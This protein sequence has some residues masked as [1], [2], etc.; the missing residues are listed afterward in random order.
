KQAV[1]GGDVLVI[2]LG[3]GLHLGGEPLHGGAVGDQRRMERLDRDQLTRGQVARSIALAVWAATEE[4]LDLVA[5]I[6]SDA[7]GQPRAGHPP[8]GLGPTAGTVEGHFHWTAGHL[9]AAVRINEGRSEGSGP[10][11]STP[12]GARPK[13]G[14]RSGA[15]SNSLS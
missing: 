2:E 11:R 14:F 4:F 12:G 15:T 5:I 9:T 10:G 3:G 13:A 6:E 8:G 1:G 7:I